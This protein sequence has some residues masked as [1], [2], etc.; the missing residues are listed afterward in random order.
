LPNQLLVGDPSPDDGPQHGQE[1]AGV[2]VRVL[3]R[4]EPDRLFVQVAEQVEGLDRDVS[5]LDRPLEQGP[6]ILRPIG[7]DLPVGVRLRAVDDAGV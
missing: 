7:V 6:E 2:A 4:G 5:P 3:A 1:S